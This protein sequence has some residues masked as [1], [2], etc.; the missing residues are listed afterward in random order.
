MEPIIYNYLATPIHGE[1]ENIEGIEL[2]EE[3]DNWIVTL[4]DRSTREFLKSQYRSV[5]PSSFLPIIVE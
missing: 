4:E 1:A 3:S 5:V 2:A